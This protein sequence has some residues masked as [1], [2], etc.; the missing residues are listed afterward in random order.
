LVSIAR[1]R[2]GLPQADAEDAV[3]D[4]YR[5]RL[6]RVAEAYAQDSQNLAYLDQSFRNYASTWL[7]SKYGA[8]ELS[9]DDPNATEEI[10]KEIV[11][12]QRPRRSDVERRVEALRR[13]TERLSD[14]D[15]RYVELRFIGGLSN[16][17]IASE[18]GKEIGAVKV[19]MHRALRALKAYTRDEGY[20][21]A[22]DDIADWPALEARIEAAQQSSA[23]GKAIGAFCQLL[24]RNGGYPTSVSIAQAARRPR[25]AAATAQFEQGTQGL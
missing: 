21:L 18:L 17:Q 11:D 1:R 3:H 24:Q 13:A 25:A 8:V 10:V 19:G 12:A 16:P 20:C 23:S 6:F 4:F 9:F 5:D 14:S 2:F 15:R 22:L 7:G